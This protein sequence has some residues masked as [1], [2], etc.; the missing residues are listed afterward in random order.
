[1][2]ERKEQWA[3]S[4]KSWVRFCHLSLKYAFLQQGICVS[5]I[6]LN[7]EEGG[8]WG[9]MPNKQDHLCPQKDDLLFR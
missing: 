6:G 1:M 7:M 2:T 8:M 3:R 9:K 4:Q 5:G